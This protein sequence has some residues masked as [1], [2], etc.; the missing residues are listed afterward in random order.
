[1][2][3]DPKERIQLVAME[4]VAAFASICDKL[5]IKEVATAIIS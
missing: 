2:L 4:A 5:T 1:M 3:N